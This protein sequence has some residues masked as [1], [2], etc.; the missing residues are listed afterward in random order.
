[1]NGLPME[2]LWVSFWMAVI[3]FAA[4]TPFALYRMFILWIHTREG[5]DRMRAVREAI[6]NRMQSWV[7]MGEH[8]V[9]HF[10]WSDGRLFS[11]DLAG[12]RGE[13]NQFGLDGKLKQQYRDL[14]LAYP[15]AYIVDWL[16]RGGLGDW[17]GKFPWRSPLRKAWGEHQKAIESHGT[18][19]GDLPEWVFTKQHTTE[20]ALW[21]TATSA[22]RYYI[23]EYWSQ[24]GGHH[25]L[26]IA[27]GETLESD[28]EEARRYQ[29]ALH[30]YKQWLEQEA[31]KGQDA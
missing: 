4:L 18:E 25:N 31:K 11:K 23:A 15:M 12:Y 21:G 30:L 26:A 5:L 24:V 27:A 6:A 16:W 9:P 20:H 7:N 14:E 17:Y 22:T 3:T 8:S 13:K 28:T 10:Y 29:Y 1:M 2:A 19:Y